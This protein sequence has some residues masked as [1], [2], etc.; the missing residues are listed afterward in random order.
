MISYQFYCGDYLLQLSSRLGRRQELLLAQPT[1]RPAPSQSS[2][3][4][5]RCRRRQRARVHRNNWHLR[6]PSYASFR[7]STTFVGRISSARSSRTNYLNRWSL[8]QVKKGLSVEEVRQI[9]SAMPMQV[10]RAGAAKAC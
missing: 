9:G 6:S 7:P 10:P 2:T 3:P 8:R 1:P 5:R 4:P